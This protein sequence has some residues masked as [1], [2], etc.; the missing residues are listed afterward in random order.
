MRSALGPMVV[1]TPSLRGNRRSSEGLFLLPVLH[2]FPRK[3]LGGETMPFK[4]NY[5]IAY[6]LKTKVFCLVNH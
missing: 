6:Q 2:K 5:C 3:D 1:V 4:E